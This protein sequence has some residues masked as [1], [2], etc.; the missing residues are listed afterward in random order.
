MKLFPYEALVDQFQRFGA[1]AVFVGIIL[2]PV[3]FADRNTI[4]NPN[5]S[6]C[7]LDQSQIFLISESFKKQ[8]NKI[9]VDLVDDMV[10]Y[11]YM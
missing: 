8:F 1:Y 4:P 10:L 6:F 11:G 9:V 3:I 2:L 5:V 7:E